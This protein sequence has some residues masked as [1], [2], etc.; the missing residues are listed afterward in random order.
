MHSS[1]R[2]LAATLALAPGLACP[3]ADLLTTNITCVNNDPVASGPT[4]FSI[5]TAQKIEWSAENMVFSRT[6]DPDNRCEIGGGFFL[7]TRPDGNE[8]VLIPWPV[9]GDESTVVSWINGTT[10]LGPGTYFVATHS[11]GVG[12]YKIL[13]NLAARV[14]VSPAAFEF[15]ARLAGEYISQSFAVSQ[16][17]DWPV[18]IEQVAF[19]RSDPHF[20]IADAN[21]IMGATIGA[22]RNFTVTFHAGSDP[23]LHQATLLVTG[24]H[25]DTTVPPCVVELWGE[26]VAR[27]PNIVFDEV[28]EPDGTVFLGRADPAT[29]ESLTASLDYLNTGTGPLVHQAETALFNDTEAGVFSFATIPSTDAMEPG[30]RRAV[31]L[32]FRPPPTAG[33]NVFHGHLVVSTNDPDEP[34][35]QCRFTAASH[36]RAPAMVVQP[37]ALLD[38]G[39]VPLG[40]AMTRS[41]SVRN[42]GDAPLTVELHDA[43]TAGAPGLRHW[44]LPPE[45]PQTVPPGGD[46]AA[47]AVFPIR[48]EPQATG[49]QTRQVR[50]VGNDPHTPS[51]EVMLAGRALPGPPLSAVLVLDRSGAMAAADQGTEKPIVLLPAITLQFVE[52]L[53]VGTDSLGI[54]TFAERAGTQMPLQP[55]TTALEQTAARLAEEADIRAGDRVEPPAGVSTLAGPAGDGTG[56]LHALRQA[57]ALV[58]TGPAGH[59]RRI[60]FV[61]TRTRP[62]IGRSHGSSRDPWSQ[63]LAAAAEIESSEGTKTRFVVI[64]RPAAAPNARVHVVPAVLPL[65]GATAEALNGLFCQLAGAN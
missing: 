32:V 38:F 56:A 58:R 28:V 64:G 40:F 37:P 7:S 14:A 41:V 61:T 45:L 23:G 26:T 65:S 27:V 29:S 2:L 9:V 43:G 8:I 21:E 22:R 20:S 5:S 12:T 15:G 1:V 34:A 63:L 17:G 49:K 33:E 54:I 4:S 30:Q 60:V 62:P 6:G 16:A 59:Q 42:S 18:K 53:R 52:F 10:N 3:A 25:P 50:V 36:V 11:M 55:L 57:A 51:Q 13:Y 46:A 47:S 31:A 48:F 39:S 35:K 24:S 19:S 44:V